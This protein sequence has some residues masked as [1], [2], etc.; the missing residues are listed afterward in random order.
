MKPGAELDAVSDAWKSKGLQE[1]IEKQIRAV[2]KEIQEGQARIP[3][4]IVWLRGFFA[5]IRWLSL[6]RHRE[7]RTTEITREM[8]EE[9]M[10][11]AKAE[12]WIF[13]TDAAFSVVIRKILH[14]AL[15]MVRLD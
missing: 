8:V 7:V 15:K 9:G 4:N 12:R 6:T 13:C 2:E 3:I 14:A 1:S 10:D 11:A 5:D